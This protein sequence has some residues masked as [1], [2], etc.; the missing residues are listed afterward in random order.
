MLNGRTSPG[1]PINFGKPSPSDPPPQ[2]DSRG[3]S[4]AFVKEDVDL[5]E[6]SVRVRSAS[7]LPPGAT[8]YMTASGEC[9][10][11]E[12]L[13]QLRAGGKEKSHEIARLEEALD[14]ATVVDLAEGVPESVAF[15]TIVTVRDPSGGQQTF[16]IVGVDEVELEESAVSWISPLGKALLGAEVG[17]RRSVV[18]AKDKLVIEKIEYPGRA[19]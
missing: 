10:L 13:E 9:E 16:H 17:E 18:G 11:R 8:N 2:N 19:G 7:G 1:G 6:R 4:R 3:M 15:G 12:R 5:P 14:S